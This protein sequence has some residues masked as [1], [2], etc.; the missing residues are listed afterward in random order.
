VH[1]KEEEEE[2]KEEDEDDSGFGFSKKY[3]VDVDG[4]QQ[5]NSRKKPRK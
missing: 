5:E 3:A 4:F 2:T 1:N